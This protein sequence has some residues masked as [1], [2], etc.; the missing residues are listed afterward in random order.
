MASEH[1][2]LVAKISTLQEVND[3]SQHGIPMPVNE[4]HTVAHDVEAKAQKKLLG[5]LVHEVSILR[6]EVGRSHKLAIHTKK[7]Q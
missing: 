5:E 3:M 4:E 7:G 1:A 2:Q 6:K